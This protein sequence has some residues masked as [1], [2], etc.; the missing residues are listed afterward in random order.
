M[1]ET[2]RS[3]CPISMPLEVFGDKWSLLILRDTLLPGSAA[4]IGCAIVGLVCLK[5]PQYCASEVVVYPHT[6]GHPVRDA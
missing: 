6:R 3:R 4:A 2:H 5:S 1:T